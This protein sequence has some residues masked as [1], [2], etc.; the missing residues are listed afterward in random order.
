MNS[1]MS[2]QNTAETERKARA[3]L[4]VG[5][6]VAFLLIFLFSRLNVPGAY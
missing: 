6:K 4:C 1:S 2:E 5:V 3:V